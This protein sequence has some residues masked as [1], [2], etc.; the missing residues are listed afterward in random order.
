M[1][2]IISNAFQIHKYK[3]DFNERL[4]AL[5][6]K[7]VKLIAEIRDIVNQLHEIQI[8][9]DPEHHLPIPVVPHMQPDEMPEK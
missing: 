7:K 4:L 8:K 3:H 9:L 2:Q 1:L 5:R 6:D